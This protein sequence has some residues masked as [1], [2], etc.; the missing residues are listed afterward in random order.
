MSTTML[1]SGLTLSLKRSIGQAESIHV[2]H[3][4]EVTFAVVAERGL[5]G[6]NSDSSRAL[7]IDS[8]IIENVACVLEKKGIRDGL[9]SC[10][11]VYLV[12]AGHPW[13]VG[14]PCALF[15]D[16]DSQ[17]TLIKT[18]SLSRGSIPCMCTPTHACGDHGLAC[19]TLLGQRFSIMLP[20]MSLLSACHTAVQ[21]REF[22]ADLLDN[23]SVEKF[24][25]DGSSGM[26]LCSDSVNELSEYTVHEGST[27][28]FSVTK[29]T[30]CE[31]RQQRRFV[32][33]AGELGEGPCGTERPYKTNG[34][35]A[36]SPLRGS[37]SVG[38]QW[39]GALS[40]CPFSI[41]W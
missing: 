1:G 10:G 3:A 28:T 38:L 25:C 33:F 32:S 35:G 23:A 41:S 34:G 9:L 6:N 7:H 13:S 40:A 4:A 39:E 30:C 17:K 22:C 27:D 2:G 19:L 12:L 37:L 21:L 8:C 15:H 18:F 31:G 20:T 29:A 36:S 26:F 5:L 11:G 14:I 24:Y 16:A